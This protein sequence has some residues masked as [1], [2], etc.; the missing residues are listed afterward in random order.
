MRKGGGCGYSVEDESDG[1]WV[2]VVRAVWGRCQI[3]ALQFCFVV[4][5]DERLWGVEVER[6]FTVL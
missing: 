5:R 4:G 3:S 6:V 1:R 2:D